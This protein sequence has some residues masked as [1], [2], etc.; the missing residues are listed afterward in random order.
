MIVVGGRGEPDAGP[1][2]SRGRSI[3]GHDLAKVANGDR[4]ARG[5]MAVGRD[6]QAAPG[7]RGPGAPRPLVLRADLGP[8]RGR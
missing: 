7:R 4:G 1:V 8:P 5:R 6:K 3:P 2:G